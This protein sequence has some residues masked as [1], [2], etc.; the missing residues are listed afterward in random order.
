[1]DIINNILRDNPRFTNWFDIDD[2]IRIGYIASDDIQRL[3][4]SNFSPEEGSAL[5]LL[6]R[7]LG[8]SITIARRLDIQ[9]F[10]TY[11]ENFY[12]QFSDGKFYNLLLDNY[13]K[14]L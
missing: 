2:T 11:Q 8:E 10:F 7:K 3:R 9:R 13:I 4:L 5:I 6:N 14:K 12:I 1:M